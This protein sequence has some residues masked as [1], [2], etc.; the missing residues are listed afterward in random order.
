M[1]NWVLAYIDAGGKN[2]AET[3]AKTA[4]LDIPGPNAPLLWRVVIALAMGD[5]GDR[6][7]GVE[8][9]RPLARA[10]PRNPDVIVAA[11]AFRH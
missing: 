10:L 9:L 2:V 11:D 3:R 4:L 7:R 5:L 6:K 1:A 8:V